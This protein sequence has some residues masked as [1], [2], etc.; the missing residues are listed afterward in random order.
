M[1]SKRKAEYALKLFCQDFGVLDKLTFDFSNEQEFKGT[2]FM[3]EVHRKGI[4]YPI[5]EP[6]LYNKNPA[7]GVSLWKRGI[8][9][10]TLW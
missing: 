1:G 10:A 8:N 9:G 3:K 6:D 2:K 4:Y 7:E 5:S